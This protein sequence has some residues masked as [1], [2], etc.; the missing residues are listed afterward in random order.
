PQGCHLRC[1]QGRGRRHHRPSG[2]GK[3]TA[4]RCMDRLETIHGGSMLI[5]GRQFH[6]DDVDL[7]SLRRDVEIVFQGYNPFSHVTVAQNIMLAPRMGVA[8][9]YEKTARNYLAIVTIAAIVLWLR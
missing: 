2:S 3:S 8:T 9:H 6:D 7:K 4:L 5:C 1:Q